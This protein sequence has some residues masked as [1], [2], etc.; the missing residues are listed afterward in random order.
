[1]QGIVPFQTLSVRWVVVHVSVCALMTG[2]FVNEQAQSNGERTYGKNGYCFVRRNG[3][4]C[5]WPSLKRQSKNL[6]LLVV[7]QDIISN[8]YNFADHVRDRHTGKYPTTLLH[9]QKLAYG[10]N[11]PPFAMIMASPIQNLMFTATF[12]PY[13]NKYESKSSPVYVC[14]TPDNHPHSDVLFWR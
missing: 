12:Q 2:R 3:K 4:S 1:M 6:K 8:T 5:L 7:T 10:L 11:L 14:K 13:G 9:I